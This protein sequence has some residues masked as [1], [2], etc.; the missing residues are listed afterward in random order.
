M[1]DCCRFNNLVYARTLKSGS[2]FFYRNFTQTAGWRPMK[3][4]EVDWNYHTV[5]SYIMDPIQRRH[6]GVAEALI[7]LGAVDTFLANN[8]SLD[9]VFEKVPFLDDHSAS[10]HSIYGDKTSMINW[11]PMTNDHSV[12]INETN[13][14]LEKHSVGPINWDAN[15]TH[16]TGSYM[17]EIYVKLKRLWDESNKCSTD[18]EMRYF[19]ADIELYEKIKKEHMLT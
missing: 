9:K 5:F 19:Q 1:I 8:S 16:A 14:F 7:M 3:L 13:K 12:A 11:L 10:L 6:K 17:S 18:P 4:S 2:E 15:Y